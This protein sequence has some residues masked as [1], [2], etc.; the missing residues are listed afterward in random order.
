MQPKYLLLGME[1]STNQGGGT[2]CW[3]NSKISFA[4]AHGSNDF[5]LESAATNK[6]LLWP[7]PITSVW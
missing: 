4:T 1:A 7:I 2:L 6:G 3:Q 5:A